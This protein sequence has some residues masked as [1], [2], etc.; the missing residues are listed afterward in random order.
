MASVQHPYGTC[1]AAPV[2]N[3]AR[4]TIVKAWAGRLKV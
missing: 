2:V 3:G 4:F 1:A